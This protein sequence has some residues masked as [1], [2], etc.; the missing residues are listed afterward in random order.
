LLRSSHNVADTSFTLRKTPRLFIKTRRRC[1]FDEPSY[2]VDPYL[3]L[4]YLLM[5][6]STCNKLANV[7]CWHADV[8][9]VST[10]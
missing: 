8:L 2:I 3:I 5:Y 7:F 10:V 9:A 4:L 6:M 1:Q